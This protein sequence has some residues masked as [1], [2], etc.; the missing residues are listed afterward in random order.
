MR[1]KTII[2]NKRKV[3]YHKKI[4]EGNNLKTVSS[5]SSTNQ[6]SRSHEGKVKTLDVQNEKKPER[7]ER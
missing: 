3:E 7:L 5:S 6:Q 4:T 1:R 2:G